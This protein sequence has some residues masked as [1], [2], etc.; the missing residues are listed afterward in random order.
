MSA[1]E[2]TWEEVVE[3]KEAE[4]ARL[5][6]ELADYD[7]VMSMVYRAIHTASLKWRDAHNDPCTPDLHRL[8]KWLGDMLEYIEDHDIQLYEG[9]CKWAAKQEVE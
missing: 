1:A 9:A 8:V 5:K 3:M 2:Y 6:E 4:I 7:R